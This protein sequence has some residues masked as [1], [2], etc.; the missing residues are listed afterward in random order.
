MEIPSAGTVR[1]VILAPGYRRWSGPLSVGTINVVKLERGSSITGTVV[2][3][4]GTGV[5]GAVV[6]VARPANRVSW[7]QSDMTFRLD[8]QGE[9]GLMGCDHDGHFTI[10]GL[11][12]G[13]VYEIGAYKD[14]YAGDRSN[15]PE[16]ARGGS[17]DVQ[18]L[19]RR[20][21][22]I[23]L[24]VHSDD[25]HVL[26]QGAYFISFRLPSGFDAAL[27]SARPATP[28][29]GTGVPEAVQEEGPSHAL[30]LDLARLTPET[31]PSDPGRRTLT[32][33]IT[34][35]AAAHRQKSI[36]VEVE[37]GTI[38]DLDIVLER[39]APDETLLPVT[40]SVRFPN[41]KRAPGKFGFEVEKASEQRKRLL[42]GGDGETESD[43]R[44]PPG[45][46]EVS[47]SS[48]VSGETA[49]YWPAERQKFAFQVQRRQDRQV[50]PVVI[51]GNPVFV[52]AI[53]ESDTRERGFDLRLEGPALGACLPWFRRW[54][55]RWR[56]GPV[57]LAN[58]SV[59]VVPPG[60]VTVRVSVP[61]VGG[62]HV[63]LIADGS[64]DALAADVTLV[65]AEE[66]R[67]ESP[68]GA[69]GPSSPTMAHPR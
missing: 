59:L 19:L 24:T 40:F 63:D 61:G 29:G 20:L 44:L 49:A 7:P 2:D 55:A 18:L 54:D 36:Q 68:P 22:R 31:L 10:R 58:A 6:W 51:R 50:V 52:R 34:I 69:S 16:L 48:G 56:N 37:E 4:N 3:L 35:Q 12:N 32:F 9:G 43:V 65:P 25:G 26:P 13:E 67:Y 42:L 27:P 53:G 30:D 47:L 39:D 15:E 17:R 1:A 60:A 45:N 28:G 57:R 11:N 14:G 21:T 66:L 62:G 5:G 8:E 23:V 38:R 46:Y 41:G 64:G 33:G